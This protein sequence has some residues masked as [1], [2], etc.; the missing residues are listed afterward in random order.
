MITHE[1][2]H[3]L[4][5]PYGIRNNCFIAKLD[6]S[7]AFDRMNWD[8]IQR[9]LQAYGFNHW[10]IERA[11]TCV[12][13]VFYRFKVNGIPSPALKPSRGL[14]Q[15]DPLSPYIFILAMDALSHLLRKAETDNF[16]SGITIARGAPSISHLLFA[17]DVILF[18][19]ADMAEVSEL[20]KIINCFT[21]ASGQK[22][23]ILKT[24]LI[25]GKK[26]LPYLKTQISQML[27]MQIWNDPGKYLGLPAQWGKSKS[28]TLSWIKDSILTKMEGW[29]ERLLNPA[30]KEV[31]IKAVIQAIPSYAMSILKFPKTFCD[32]ICVKIAKFW[33]AN[34][35]KERGIHWRNW[36][37]LTR[38][39]RNGGLGFRD[40]SLMNLALLAKQAW[41]IVNLP[42]AL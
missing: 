8:F 27:N 24:G 28:Q 41:R 3:A 21:R 35:S 10:W 11:M 20:M 38:S 34:N 29:K 12:K 1:I 23:N 42:D 4:K 13:G 26:V 18:A 9:C 22:V 31:L 39:K 36:Q 19:K 6:M 25:F 7:K 2:L 37:L 30:G 14:H 15:G 32:S 33:W 40:F 17:D 5:Q 16:I